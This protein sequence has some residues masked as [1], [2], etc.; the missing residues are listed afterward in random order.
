MAIT[1]KKD[2]LKYPDAQVSIS[3]PLINLVS[4][5]TINVILSKRPPHTLPLLIDSKLALP[6]RLELSSTE[7][8]YVY[9]SNLSLLLTG[10]PMAQPFDF[11]H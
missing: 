8:Q 3:K 1:Y 5:L 2:E 4:R 10:K 6:F 11:H 9:I 7:K